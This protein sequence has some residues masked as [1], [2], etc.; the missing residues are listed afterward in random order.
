M[1]SVADKQYNLYHI[2]FSDWSHIVILSHSSNNFQTRTYS[3][4]LNYYRSPF[5]SNKHDEPINKYLFLLQLNEGTY[6]YLMCIKIGDNQKRETTRIQ[7]PDR[8]SMWN[9]HQ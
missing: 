1:K 8:N 5:S 9:K 6:L 7:T 4:Y 3:I 2:I